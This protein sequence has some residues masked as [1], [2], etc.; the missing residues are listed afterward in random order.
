MYREISTEMFSESEGKS[1]FLIP[2]NILMMNFIIFTN[3][4]IVDYV[5]FHKF[6]KNSEI[7]IDFIPNEISEVEWIE[8]GKMGH[9]VEEKLSKNQEIAPWF[10]KMIE[11]GLEEWW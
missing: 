10:T 8:L 9:F 6:Q 5:L 4:L 1:Y 7:N 3:I 11:F 2:F